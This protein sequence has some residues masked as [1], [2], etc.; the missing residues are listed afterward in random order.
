MDKWTQKTGQSFKLAAH[1]FAYLVAIID[2][3]ARRVL[4][5]SLAISV[6]L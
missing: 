5:G 1:G 6:I 3:Y 2:W 4:A